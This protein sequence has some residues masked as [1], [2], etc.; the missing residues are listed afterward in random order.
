MHRTNCKYKTKY[1]FYFPPKSVGFEFEKFEKNNDCPLMYS[2]WI[3]FLG[4][5]VI[6]RTHLIHTSEIVPELREKFATGGLAP[7]QQG[8]V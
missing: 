3:L 6:H 5:V 7:K 1:R 2:S 4:R 8:E